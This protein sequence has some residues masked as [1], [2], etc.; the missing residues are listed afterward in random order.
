MEQA[1]Q[2]YYKEATATKVLAPDE[3]EKCPG[4]VLGARRGRGSKWEESICGL[5]ACE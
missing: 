3:L 2:G 4:V 5:L 1:A